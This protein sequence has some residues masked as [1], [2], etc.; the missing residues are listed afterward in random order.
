[1]LKIISEQ[2]IAAGVR[3]VEALTGTGALEH[4][5]RA[6]QLLTQDNR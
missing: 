2:S 5:Q 4:Y 1:M 3:R 6:A